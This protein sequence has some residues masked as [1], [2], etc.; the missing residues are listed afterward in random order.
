MKKSKRLIKAL[1]S[2]ESTILKAITH[3]KIA[4]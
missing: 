1:A 4:K 3:V 2:I